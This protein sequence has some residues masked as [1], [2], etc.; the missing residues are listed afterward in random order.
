MKQAEQKLRMIEKIT[1]F[2]E[3]KIKQEFLKL[4]EDLRKE[5]KSIKVEKEKERKRRYIMEGLK[6]ELAEQQ[7]EKD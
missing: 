4:E 1:K 5:E 7:I 3:E 2:R 6:K